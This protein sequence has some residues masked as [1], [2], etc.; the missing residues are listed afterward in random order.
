M[1]YSTL[2]LFSGEEEGVLVTWDSDGTTT[3]V[4]RP[5]HTLPRLG[6]GGIVYACPGLDGPVGDGGGGGG[7]G[8]V[9]ITGVLVYISDNT[10]QMIS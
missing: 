6:R 4:N 3:S 10:L 2:S 1:S 5:S 9:G 7:G 8:G